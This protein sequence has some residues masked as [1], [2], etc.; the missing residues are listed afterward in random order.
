MTF[1]KEGNSTKDKKNIHVLIFILII[2]FQSAVLH[3]YL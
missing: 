3:T 2:I 1:Q